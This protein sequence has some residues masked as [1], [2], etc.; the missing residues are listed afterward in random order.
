MP[1]STARHAPRAFDR[2]GPQPNDFALME[3]ALNPQLAAPQQFDDFKDLRPDADYWATQSDKFRTQQVPATVARP[4][5]SAD[6]NEVVMDDV[7]FMLDEDGKPLG[8]VRP[9]AAMPSKQRAVRRAW[10]DSE[11]LQRQH[12]QQHA[13]PAAVSLAQTADEA[14]EQAQ[15]EEAQA[16]QVPQKSLLQQVSNHVKGTMYDLAHF[17][18]LPGDGVG[19]KLKYAC[20][21]DNRMWTIVGL[22]LCFVLLICIVI[23]IAILVKRG[24]T[25]R[26]TGLRGGGGGGRRRFRTMMYPQRHTRRSLPLVEI[27]D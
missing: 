1:T 7:G 26:L 10:R 17:S 13:K 11:A 19:A 3:A 8:N 15:L 22:V 18:E 4:V 5:I 23:V 16:L 21:R 2:L 9:L 25:R 24:G 20:T 6:L 12:R 14:E 27:A